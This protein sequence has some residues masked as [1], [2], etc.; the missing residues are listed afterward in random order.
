MKNLEDIVKDIKPSVLI[1]NFFCFKAMTFS[2]LKKN[3]DVALS[4]DQIK[5]L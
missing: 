5:F 1:G 4:E 2:L 3:G